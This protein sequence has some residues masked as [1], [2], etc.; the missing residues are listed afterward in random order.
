MRTPMR[1]R[2]R[3]GLVLVLA[4]WLAAAGAA[5]AADEAQPATPKPLHAYTGMVQK[6]SKN[7]VVVHVHKLPPQHSHGQG[8]R[9]K[10][11]AMQVAMDKRWTYEQVTTRLG[12]AL[13]CRPENLR[14][15]MHN[16]YSDLPKP[17]PRPRGQ[18]AQLLEQRL[19]LHRRASPV[20]IASSSSSQNATWSEAC[21]GVCIARSV[22]PS[23][24]VTS[25]SS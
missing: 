18:L 8:V 13:N 2:K 1:E 11:R 3:L 22:A 6:V 25:S 20:K 15:T 12:A 23:A 9:E 10:E 17:Q 16:P 5:R 14:L 24:I 7:R 4:G 21:P 19:L